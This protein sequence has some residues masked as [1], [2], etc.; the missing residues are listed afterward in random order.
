MQYVPETHLKHESEL[1]T[2]WYLPA[3]HEVQTVADTTEYCPA[4][5]VPETTESPPEAQT[6]PA[7]QAITAESPVDGQ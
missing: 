4:A 2:L 7:G 6:L 1:P 3:A 5:H